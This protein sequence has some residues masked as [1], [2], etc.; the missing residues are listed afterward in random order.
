MLE[1][2]NE[3]WSHRFSHLAGVK[4]GQHGRKWDVTGAN[5]SISLAEKICWFS[6]WLV[7]I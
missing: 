4:G 1:K 5:S 2:G 3:L 7:L 6:D